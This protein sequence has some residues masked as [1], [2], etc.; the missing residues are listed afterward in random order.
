MVRAWHCGTAGP[1][2]GKREMLTLQGGTHRVAKAVR[3]LLKHADSHRKQSAV[4]QRTDEGSKCAC[5]KDNH[6]AAHWGALDRID[7]LSEGA[8]AL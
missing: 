7:R 1:A 6:D 8:T 5:K 3:S 4:T 2:G